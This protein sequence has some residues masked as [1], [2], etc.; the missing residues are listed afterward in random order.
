MQARLGVAHGLHQRLDTLQR[1]CLKS[2]HPLVVAEREGLD[3]IG[4]H[5]RKIAGRHA[6]LRKDAAALLRV[7]HVPVVGA[8]ERVD[9][10]PVPRLLAHD[11]AGQVRL[12]E[13]GGAVQPVA[14]PAQF[15]LLPELRLSAEIREGLLQMLK[16][17]G[18]PP[19]HEVSVGADTGVVVDAADR[20][21][22]FLLEVGEE[23]ASFVDKLAALGAKHPGE[24]AKHSELQ[25][26]LRGVEF[27][28]VELGHGFCPF[29][30]A[31]Q[32]KRKS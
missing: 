22:A 10:N 3:G 12:V 27:V 18:V 2:E 1:R 14:D 25:K 20:D 23:G 4:S 28:K 30:A 11:E 24:R 7:H 21:Y 13:L 5:I 16:L 15:H 8:H 29:P 19:D 9:R 6:V 17:F 26:A 31:R 32:I